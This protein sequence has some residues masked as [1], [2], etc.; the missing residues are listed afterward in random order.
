VTYGKLIQE[1]SEK[2]TTLVERVLLFSRT[3][4][5]QVTYQKECVAV[6]ELV[7]SAVEMSTN[8][9]DPLTQVQLQLDG[10]LPIIRTDAEQVKSALRNVIENAIKYGTVGSESKWVG[11]FASVEIDKYGSWI[12]VRVEDHGPGIPKDEQGRIFEPFF[13]GRR[14]MR[15]QIHGSGLGLNIARSAIEAIGGSIRVMSKPEKGTEFVVRLPGP[16]AD[17]DCSNFA[18]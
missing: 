2:L 12:Q 5:A 3:K 1:Q 16:R 10:N 8:G 15:D 4:S 14:A 11:V 9:M 7:K 18:G 13:R 17:D 6:E